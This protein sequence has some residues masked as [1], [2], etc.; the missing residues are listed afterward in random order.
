MAVRYRD[1]TVPLFSARANGVV[2][3]GVLAVLFPSAR[4]IQAEYSLGDSRFD[5]M[6]Q[7]G[8]G[9][10]HL[11]EVKACSLVEEGIAMFPDAPSERAVKHIEELAELT[12]QGYRCHILFM[13]AHGNPQRFIPN[14]HTDPKFASTLSHAAGAIGVHAVTLKANEQGQGRIINMNVPVDLSFGSLAEANR[15]SYMIVLEFPREITIQVGALGSVFFKAGWYVYAGSAQKQLSQRIARHLRHVRKQPHWHL[16][17]LTPH[18]GKIAGLPIASYENLECELS[19]SLKAIG[20]EPVPRF[21]STDCG[22][23]SH[24]YYFN[25]PP[26]KLRDFL[27]VLF[28]F[29]H[30]RALNLHG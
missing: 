20:G 7:D 13:I 17:Y 6:V 8:D 15:G 26:L 4:H 24:L 25:I 27:T 5:F 18:A 23:E 14:L 12:Q 22:C 16:D 21:G 9:V 19:A 3:Q 28:S 11:I 1:S 10:T 2:E 29:R 30:R